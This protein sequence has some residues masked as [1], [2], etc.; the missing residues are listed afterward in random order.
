[1]LLVEPGE[2]GVRGLS[3]TLISG[4]PGDEMRVSFSDCGGLAGSTTSTGL[5][6]IL[7]MIDKTP[8]SLGIII[9]PFKNS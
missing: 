2:L 1:M 9:Y 7:I 6:S 3:V 5:L 4:D 8:F